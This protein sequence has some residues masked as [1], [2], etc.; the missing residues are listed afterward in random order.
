MCKYESHKEA[1]L[2]YHFGELLCT[3]IIN[4]N[5]KIGNVSHGTDDV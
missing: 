1:H 5:K 2:T 4:Y 3:G